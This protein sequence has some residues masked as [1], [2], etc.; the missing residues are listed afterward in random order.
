MVINSLKKTKV[1]IYFFFTPAFPN[2]I[3]FLHTTS[4]LFAVLII[5]D[6]NK[7]KSHHITSRK[8]SS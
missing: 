3:S 5:I 8:K 7:I 4:D 1:F 6:F 2:F